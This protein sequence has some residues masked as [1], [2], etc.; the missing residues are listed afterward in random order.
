MKMHGRYEKGH[1]IRDGPETPQ[2]YLQ[3]D[4]VIDTGRGLGPIDFAPK[5][6]ITSDIPHTLNGSASVLKRTKYGSAPSGSVGSS[7]AS[8]PATTADAWPA[9]S[10]QRTISAKY[11]PLPVESGFCA[12]IFRMRIRATSPSNSNHHTVAQRE[13]AQ[14]DRESRRQAREKS[15]AQRFAK[16]CPH[17]CAMQGM[18]EP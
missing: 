6:G 2:E 9:E 15:K 16:I 7:D 14:A 3:Y 8:T 18:I 12:E 5:Y 17:A 13:A 11:T 10:S 1:R 4:C